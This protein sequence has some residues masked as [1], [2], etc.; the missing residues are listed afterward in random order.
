VIRE[1]YSIIFTVNDNSSTSKRQQIQYI[2]VVL[3]SF[4]IIKHHDLFITFRTVFLPM[5]SRV[6]QISLRNRSFIRCNGKI[7]MPVV[8]M[9]SFH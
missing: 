8:Y 5:D 2:L 4:I 7:V 1:H 3:K 6:D 9:M